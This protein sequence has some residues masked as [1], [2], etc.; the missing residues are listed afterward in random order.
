M[1]F[2]KTEASTINYLNLSPK[3]NIFLY[4]LLIFNNF[5]LIKFNFTEFLTKNTLSATD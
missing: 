5:I 3:L 2:Y 4:M 1:Q